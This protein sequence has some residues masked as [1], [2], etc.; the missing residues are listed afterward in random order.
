MVWGIILMATATAVSL[1][2]AW[3]GNQGVRDF[4]EKGHVSFVDLSTVG[5]NQR[6]RT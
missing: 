3:L 6:K 2:L 4:D 5:G 1:W